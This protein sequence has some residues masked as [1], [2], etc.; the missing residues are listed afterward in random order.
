MF[1]FELRSLQSINSS[2]STK[3]HILKERL[4]QVIL[5]LNRYLQFRNR[6]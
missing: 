1:L 2:T 4:F 6:I 5:N 3:D